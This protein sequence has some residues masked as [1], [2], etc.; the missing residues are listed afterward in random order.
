MGLTYFTIAEIANSHQ[1]NISQLKELAL[2]V[3]N[4]DFDAIKFQIYQC[5]EL[6]TKAAEQTTKLRRNE[7][8]KDQWILFFKWFNSKRDEFAKRGRNLKLLIEPYGVNS[9]KTADKVQFIDGFKIPTSDTLNKL[10]LNQ[11]LLRQKKIIFVGTGGSTLSELDTTINYIRENEALDHFYLTHGFQAYPTNASDS[12]LWKISFL[13]THFKIHVGY[14]DH[15]SAYSPISRVLTSCAALIQGASF[16][17]KH[18]INER[19]ETFS[20]N[21]SSITPVE[22]SEFFD[23]LK[24]ASTMSPHLPTDSLRDKSDYYLNN[25]ENIYRQS[26]KKFLCA[27]SHLRKGQRLTEES[28][29]FKRVPGGTL[30]FQNFEEV[31]GKILSRDIEPDQPISFKYLS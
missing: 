16:I 8:T 14:A 4:S 19:H 24:S 10:L 27:A 11:I 5:D 18:V 22:Y 12:D 23:A 2:S 29:V 30:T 17:E 25:N 28:I 7:F 31:L 6:L 1:G 13:K 21:Y 15:A 3:L 20:D 9:L 26:M